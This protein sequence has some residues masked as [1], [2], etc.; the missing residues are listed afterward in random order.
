MKRYSLLV[1]LCTSGLGCTLMNPPDSEDNT[2]KTADVRPAFKPPVVAGQ[3]NATNAQDK[4]KA[5][6]DE[7]DREL[8]AAIETRDKAK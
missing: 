6:N 2:V 4:A 5:L 3:L 7:L 1:L 8:Q